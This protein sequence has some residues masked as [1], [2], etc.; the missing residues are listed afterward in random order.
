LTAF[1]STQSEIIVPIFDAGRDQIVGT[2]DVENEHPNAFDEK[3]ESLLVMCADAIA[4]LW[5]NG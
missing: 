2:I 5:W 4:P 3:S 1:G